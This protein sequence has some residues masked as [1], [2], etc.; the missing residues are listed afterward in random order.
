[1]EKSKESEN[2][3]SETREDLLVPLIILAFIACAWLVYTYENRT[4][5][6]ALQQVASWVLNPTINYTPVQIDGV[7]MAFLA[8]IVVLFLGFVFSYLLLGNEKD[9]SVKL[10]SLIGLGFGLTG[11]ITIILGIFGNLFQFPLNATLLLLLMLSLSVLLYR[12]KVKEKLTIKEYLTP[13]IHIKKLHFPSNFKFWL[14]ICVAIGVIFFFCFYHALFT[15]ITHWDSLVYHATM[16]VFMY[17]EHAIPVMAGTSIG[18]QMS[19][20]FPPLFSALGAYYYIQIGSIQDIFLRV[21]PPVMCTLTVLATYKIGELLAGKKFGLISALLLTVTPLFFRYSIF[22]T[23]YSTLTFFCTVSILFLLLAIVKGNTKYWI[24]AGLFFGFASLTSYIALY[25]APFLLI[26]IT[27]YVIYRKNS[28]RINIKKVLI[29]LSS[30]LIIGSVWYLRNLILVGNPIYPNAY[31]VL[32]GINIDPLIEQVTFNQIKWSATLS[33]FGGQVSTFDQIMIFLTYRTHFPSISLLTVLGLALLPTQNKKFWLISAWPLM[34]SLFILSGVSWGF[35]RHVVFAMPGFALLSALPIMKALDVCKQYDLNISKEKL[36]QIGNRLPPIRKSNIIRAGLVFLLFVA[37]LF[38]SLTLSM[39]G[40]I[41]AES[42]DDPVSDDYLYFLENPNSE[43]W[44]ALNITYPEAVAWQFMND[45]LNPGEKFATIENRIYYVKNCSND[46]FFY[47]DGWEARELYNI[48]DPTLMVQ[49]LRNENVKY[50]LDVLWARIHG[51]DDV[52]PMAKY[53]DSP[54][55]PTLM[56]HSFNP[57][58]YNVGPLETP[59]TNGSSTIISINQPGWSELQST[60]GVHTQSVIAGNNSA[61]LYVCTPN[62]TSLKITYLDVGKDIL[63][64]NVHAPDSKEWIH[65]YAVI[66]K[67]NTGKWK[68]YEFVAPQSE[69]GFVEFGLHAYTENFT[70]SKIYAAPCQSEN[71]ST[72]SL[73]AKVTSTTAPAFV[74]CSLILREAEKI[75]DSIKVHG[76]L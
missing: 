29:L 40:K 31:T 20:N 75:Q 6:A 52:L 12:K 43:V 27:F 66:Q 18:I 55:F 2:R 59:I 32:G 11:L 58:I 56:D 61:R 17:N 5:I 68:N 63:S 26:A 4:W 34:L 30:I 16:S 21:I 46:Y 71:V 14:P 47:L 35:P 60:G 57:N 13:C 62:I 10:L 53:L 72:G 15:V 39:A 67:N 37:F 38:P 41:N 50:V 28:F 33:F 3:K 1:L 42:L 44:S 45:H 51:H 65:D 19:A 23:S 8:T 36:F 48:T 73:N 70:I 22:A 25:L 7:P 76:N 69:T 9:S 24:S 49:F 54:Y 74:E 64:V